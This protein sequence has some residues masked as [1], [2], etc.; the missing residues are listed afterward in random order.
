MEFVEVVDKP[1]QTERKWE[2][3]FP[4]NHVWI[5]PEIVSTKIEPLRA[6]QKIKDQLDY[7]YGIE[8]EESNGSEQVSTVYILQLMASC[9]FCEAGKDQILHSSSFVKI[10]DWSEDSIEEF[11]HK[12][13]PAFLKSADFEPCL[14][15]LDRAFFDSA[16][17]SEPEKTYV[18]SDPN[19][20]NFGISVEGLEF[21]NP[22]QMHFNLP[23]IDPMQHAILP[24][25]GIT[26]IYSCSKCGEHFGIS[27]FENCSRGKSEQEHELKLAFL[28][29]TQDCNGKTHSECRNRTTI[30]TENNKVKISM[31]VFDDAYEIVFD[32]DLGLIELDGIR[33]LT[34]SS[35]HGFNLFFD[36]PFARSMLFEDR[37]ILFKISSLLPALPKGIKWG[38]SDENLAL[39]I[40]ANRF[41]GYPTD[42]YMRLKEYR[43]FFA[44][45]SINNGLPRK[46]EDIEV[47][48]KMTGLPD[49]KSI[50]RRL[51]SDPIL[52][53]RLLD[54]PSLPFDDPNIICRFLDSNTGRYDL[55]ASMGLHRKSWRN[56][57]S[58]GWRILAKLKGE[59][60]LLRFLTTHDHKEIRRIAEA[61]GGGM[62]MHSPRA[63]AAIR[64]TPLSDIERLLVILRWE[65]KHPAM[66]LDQQYEY[67]VQ[68]KE[69]EA[70]VGEFKFRLPSC[71]RDYVNAGY[72]L[73]NCMGD[74]LPYQVK[75]NERERH[76]IVSCRKKI[77]GGIAI[78]D[79]SKVVEARS[80][81]NEPL[82]VVD[83]L[84]E[85][86]EQWCADKNIELQH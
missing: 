33:Y 85:A 24:E 35:S 78:E 21:H 49:K 5:K 7:V 4:Y 17:K 31:K 58:V 27:T 56:G 22:N 63:K 81:C 73:H 37:E 41:I 53:F 3:R 64:K 23:G 12:L 42:F 46:Y 36:H 59:A 26:G 1:P 55:M 75:N 54:N 80:Y 13:Y 61:F 45:C 70:D 39:L 71:A 66:E 69:L 14:D 29:L 60:S 38:S 25:N 77:V 48:F 11:F 19:Q 68:E 83:G 67:T 74:L 34:N 32:K 40:L 50:K 86:F 82:Y 43:N 51:L 76:I 9:P 62:W 30:S 2:F 20:N 44:I 84:N 65:C 79:C 15:R 18:V 16:S 52:L 6:Y 47:A 28:Q 10:M 57:S 8:I 72:E